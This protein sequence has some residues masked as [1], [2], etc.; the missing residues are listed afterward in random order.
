MRK[1]EKCHNNNKHNNNSDN[2]LTSRRTNGGKSCQLWQLVQWEVKG[3]SELRSL[4]FLF[5]LPHFRN[6]ELNIQAEI[7]TFVLLL[8]NVSI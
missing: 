4:L 2:P 6:Y 7:L 1:S 8:T 3:P 5:F